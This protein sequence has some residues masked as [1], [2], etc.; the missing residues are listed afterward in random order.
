MHTVAAVSAAAASDDDAAA[1]A[2]VLQDMI[3]EVMDAVSDGE[4]VMTTTTTTKNSNSSS[5][6]GSS[7]NGFGFLGTAHKAKGLEWKVVFV[8]LNKTHNL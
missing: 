4:R 7:V 6:S 1:Y 8:V 5:S 2:S 3:E